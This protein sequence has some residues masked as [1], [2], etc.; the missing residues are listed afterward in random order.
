[1]RRLGQLLTGALVLQMCVTM[2]WEDRAEMVADF[3][4]Y[5]RRWISPGRADARN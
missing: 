4:E 5:R 2:L 3:R 1:M